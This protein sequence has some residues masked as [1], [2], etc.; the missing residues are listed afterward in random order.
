MAENKPFGID[1]E[2]WTHTC[3]NC[4]LF[5][6]K[7][8]EDPAIKLRRC[9]GCRKMFY[10]S[11][12]CQ[13]EH[14][15][16][17]HKAHCKFFSGSK[18]LEDTVVHNEST[19]NYCII[20]KEF[21]DEVLT[22][23]NPHYICLFS[24]LNGESGEKLMKIQLS[25]PTPSLGAS[26]D[27]RAERMVDLLQRLLL[28]IKVTKQPVYQ[29]Y[30]DEVEFIA[31]QLLIVKTN[32][33]NSR[34]FEPQECQDPF[35]FGHISSLIKDDMRNVPLDSHFQMWQSFLMLADLHYWLSAVQGEAILKR[36]EKSL[37]KEQRKI[38]RAVK[39]S[40]FL[41]LVDQVLEAFD[42]RVVTH[43]YLADIVCN[44]DLRR[45]CTACEKDIT[46]EGFHY[47]GLQFAGVP[48]IVFSPDRD[49]V[50]SCGSASCESALT[51]KEQV[52]RWRWTVEAAV[53]LLL[54]TRCNSSFLLAPISKVHRYICR[55]S[56]KP[57]LML[58]T[59]GRF[60]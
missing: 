34:T 26:Q 47:R 11:K 19:C 4:R 30:P 1:C 9:S 39:Q 58:L 13:E 17:V 6:W 50:F 40:S 16:K 21:G 18:G 28:K 5:R 59:P 52:N 2:V 24:P 35:S 55:T 57:D 32:C 27:R 12:E 22:E 29:L 46:I 23:D 49:D 8:P 38:S 48:V 15:G 7:Q 36:P 33:I 60:A 14:W 31:S 54:P 10:C 3:A 51:S 45:A 43:A 41:N 25:Y 44:G 42:L 53:T 20:Q 56:L 37:P